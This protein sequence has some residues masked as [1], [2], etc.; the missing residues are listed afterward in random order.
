MDK[1]AQPVRVDQIDS[2]REQLSVV[3]FTADTAGERWSF[4][5][6]T[7]YTIF[8]TIVPVLGLSLRPNTLAA[9]VTKT[10]ALL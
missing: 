1:L 4:F 6:T 3:A 10:T 8:P 2:V 5:K 9:P 7:L